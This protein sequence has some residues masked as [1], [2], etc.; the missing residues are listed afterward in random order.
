[1]LYRSIDKKKNGG[2]FGCTNWRPVE[3]Y[4]LSTIWGLWTTVQGSD[5]FLAIKFL[6]IYVINCFWRKKDVVRLTDE[7]RL[8]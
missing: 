7:Q 4:E 3:I 1:M 6:A 5:K 2:Q 8:F